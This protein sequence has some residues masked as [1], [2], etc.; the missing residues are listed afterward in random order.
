MRIK[1][2]N[3]YRVHSCIA[4]AQLKKL[5]YLHTEADTACLNMFDQAL[6]VCLKRVFDGRICMLVKYYIHVLTFQVASN[7]SDLCIEMK[8]DNEMVR[9]VRM[10]RVVDR[11]SSS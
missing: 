8:K 11:S 1:K 6:L 7:V 4:L 3:K 9:M 2:K 5:K 10:V